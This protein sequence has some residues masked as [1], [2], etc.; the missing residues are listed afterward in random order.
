MKITE[1]NLLCVNQWSYKYSSKFAYFCTFHL[2]S[3]IIVDP[4][5]VFS[6]FSNNPRRKNPADLNLLTLEAT[7]LVLLDLSNDLD[8]ARLRKSSQ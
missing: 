5:D 4:L 1:A 2:V 8:I 3:R 7:G 6:Y